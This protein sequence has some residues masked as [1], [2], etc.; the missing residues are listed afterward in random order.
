MASHRK[1]KNTIDNLHNDSEFQACEKSPQ[2]F[3]VTVN[4]IGKNLNKDQND[5]LLNVNNISL[6]QNDTK[7]PPMS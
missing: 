6:Y 2:L 1:Q 5:S 4:Q 3:A 7:K